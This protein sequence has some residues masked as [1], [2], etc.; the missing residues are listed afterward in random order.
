[1]FSQLTWKIVCYTQIVIIKINECK[2]M[3]SVV[4]MKKNFLKFY[5]KLIIHAYI[6][7]HILYT[8]IRTFASFQ[9]VVQ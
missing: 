4:H 5:R 2:G 6:L 7:V 3:L 1:M 9:E 8:Y